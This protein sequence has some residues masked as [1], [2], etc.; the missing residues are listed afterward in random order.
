MEDAARV[1]KRRVGVEQ[2]VIYEEEEEE[3]CKKCP[4]LMQALNTR[5]LWWVIETRRSGVLS[6]HQ[7]H[8]PRGIAT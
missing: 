5:E 2:T 4:A 6:G 1:Q 3:V 8:A 7:F